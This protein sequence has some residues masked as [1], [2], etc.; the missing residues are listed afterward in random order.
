MISHFITMRLKLRELGLC[1][2]T[3]W[4][5]S[6]GLLWT[7]GSPPQ[8]RFPALFMASWD[9]K[10][11]VMTQS[12]VMDSVWWT[13]P[14]Q[15]YGQASHCLWRCFGWFN[16]TTGSSISLF[17]FQALPPP[18]GRNL[19]KKYSG[20]MEAFL[21]L[22]PHLNLLGQDRAQTLGP[23]PLSYTLDPGCPPGFDVVLV[24]VPESPVG[25]DL[26]ST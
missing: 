23:W 6:P 15:L 19:W 10:M 8:G 26:S 12:P 11:G 18:A 9:G 17:L 7:P 20:K 21:Q 24:N 25:S 14:S 16:H 22:S 3:V 5:L 2:G 13:G 1:K 4:A